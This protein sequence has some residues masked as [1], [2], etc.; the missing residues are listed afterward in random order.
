MAGQVYVH[1]ALFPLPRGD[2]CDSMFVRGASS[3]R[4]GTVML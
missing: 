4:D 3:V 2:S 1:L